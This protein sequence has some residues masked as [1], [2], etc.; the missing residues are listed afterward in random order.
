MRVGKA[1]QTVALGV[2][3][4]REKTR[5]AD[6]FL[7][8]GTIAHGWS[9]TIDWD[10]SAP[11]LAFPTNLL[12]GRFQMILQSQ[13]GRTH[14]IEASPD[15]RSWLPQSTNIMV[16]TN[17]AIVFPAANVQPNRFFRVLRCPNI[18]YFGSSLF[19]VE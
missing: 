2:P 3:F 11:R 18:D 7:D 4:S 8:E 1:Q 16:G 10:D 9:L 19:S 6:E 15:L 17:M 13:A 12:D 14:I 5:F